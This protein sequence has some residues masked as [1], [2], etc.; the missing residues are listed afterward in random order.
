M[1]ILLKSFKKIWVVIP[2]SIALSSCLDDNVVDT[3]ASDDEAID[4]YLAGNNI[5]AERTFSGLR[6]TVISE[7]NGA[8]LESN[9]VADISYELSFLESGQTIENNPSYMFKPA[10]GTFAPGLTEGS[11]LMQ[12]G[13]NYR[14]YIPSRL[15]FGG[16]SGNFSGV[17]IPSNSNFIADVKLNAVRTDA[18]Q[19]AFEIGLINEHV[20]NVLEDIIETNESP[21]G[22]VKAVVTKGVGGD[23]PYYGAFVTV[24]YNGS[25]LN[26][27]E[28]DR[29]LEF[30][31]ALDTVS[32]IKGWYDAI[33]QMEIGEDAWIVMPSD[34]AY[35]ATG[36][37]DIPPFAPLRFRIR[38]LGFE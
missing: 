36:S 10:I 2:L 29:S 32:L 37:A 26:G 24:S 13:D 23:T 9:L 28:F 5:N 33:S 15:A 7:G 27:Q 17:F 20:T 6:Y 11:L 22:V 19:K 16:T 35:G 25:L 4:S 1:N 8:N 14:F 30:S 31:I 12:E 21:S 18:E 34:R 38:L 3:S